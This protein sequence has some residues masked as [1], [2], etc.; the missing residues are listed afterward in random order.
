MA[1]LFSTIYDRALSKMNEYSYAELDDE[2]IYDSM[3]PY[4]LSAEAD[5][6][7]LSEKPLEAY[8]SVDES[9]NVVESGY[10]E[11][12]S[13]E[14]IEILACGILYYWIT[15]YVA[16]ADKLRNALG[17]KDFSLFSPANLLTSIETVRRNLEMEY[18]GKINLYSFLHGNIIRQNRRR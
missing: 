7:R 2:E 18:R 1:T 14:V 8:E 4:L 5:F 17:T 16:D 6:S 3:E 11:D 12:L 10:T 15:A 13:N 9:G